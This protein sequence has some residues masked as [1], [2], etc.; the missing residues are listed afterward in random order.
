MF[1]IYSIVNHL[2]IHIDPVFL[3]LFSRIR[4]CQ[5]LSRVPCASSRSLLITSF[6]YSRVYRSVPVSQF[7]PPPPYP[8]VTID[9]FL[10]LTFCFV[11]KLICTLF[12]DPMWKWYRDVCVCLALSSL[13]IT[14]S[15]SIHVAADGVFHS[16]LRLS[17]IPLYI[18]VPHLYP[19]LC[20]WTFGFFPWPGYCK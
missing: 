3:I 6:I 13:S 7:I 19:F 14:I 16:F 4:H 8:L 20:W 5:V 2:Y 10:Y 9:L 17:S 11:D 15:R 1:Q 12:L 18:Y